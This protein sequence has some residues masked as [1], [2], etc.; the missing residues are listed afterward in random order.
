[1]GKNR[2]IHKISDTRQISDIDEQHVKSTSV[3]SA[4]DKSFSTKRAYIA[5]IWFSLVLSITCFVASGF[6]LAS[7]ELLEDGTENEIRLLRAVRA[8]N[9]PYLAARILPLAFNI[10]VAG[11][12]DALSYVHATSL[13]WALIHEGRLQF[14]SNLRL[15]TASK[16]GWANSRT[17][18]F[19]A[20]VLLVICYTAS[21]QL[22]PAFSYPFGDAPSTVIVN[23]LA[24][25]LLGAGLF[26]LSAIALLSLSEGGS[27]ILSWSPD[28]LINTHACIQ[29]GTLTH[30]PDRG[31]MPVH[32]ASMPTQYLAASLRQRPVAE[33]YKATRKVAH[34]LWALFA[35]SCGLAGIICA[36]TFTMNR[37]PTLRFFDDNAAVDPTTDVP[38]GQLWWP[39]TTLLFLGFFWGA[40]FQAFIT[41][42][43]HC[44]EL[45]V[46]VSRDEATWRAATT[47]AG[48]RLVSSGFSG[49]SRSW[50]WYV[51]FAIKPL[52]QWLFGS[53]GISFAVS[54]NA[55]LD[56]NAL[57]LFVLIPVALLLALL[58]EFLVRRRRKGPQP[59]AFGHLATLADLVDDW[60]ECG[61]DRLYW[62]V[63]ETET[64]N[65][66]GKVGTASRQELVQDVLPDR[67]YS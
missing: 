53:A 54:Y 65:G 27:K 32:M 9:L 29:A 34:V 45:L 2:D 63:K 12:T 64:I 22:F 42:A 5:A 18:N 19:L 3:A 10:V 44:M 62:G 50:Q 14:N 7:N 20:A 52:S 17:V 58:A 66:Q 8:I 6:V 1:M 51:L 31:M 26:G 25:A 38:I 61:A 46:N 59:A 24:L 16:R 57:P 48:A 43:L 55:A 47:A 13:R 35:L 56:F 15:F 67:L 21:G 37:V 60:G 30:R 49:A 23:G 36:I 39:A 4:Y 41:L 33:A 11:C 28:P 40:F